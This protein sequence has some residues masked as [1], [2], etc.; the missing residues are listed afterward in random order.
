MSAYDRIRAAAQDRVRLQLVLDHN[1]S[2]SHPS[3]IAA[4]RDASG[5]QR[6]GRGVTAI[7][8]PAL[9]VFPYLGRR[10][11]ASPPPPISGLSALYAITNRLMLRSGPA[12]RARESSE[13]VSK[14]ISPD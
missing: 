3:W 9:T 14:L 6:A 1:S 8:A 12:G 5:S 13:K 2:G 4:I 7:L 10:E 11:S